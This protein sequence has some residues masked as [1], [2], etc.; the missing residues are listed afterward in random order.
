VNQKALNVK[1]IAF[2]LNKQTGKFASSCFPASV[3][4]LQLH[5]PGFG[6]PFPWLHHAQA[7]IAPK[8]F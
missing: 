7:T 4:K 5:L 1:A 2:E 3:L 8:L 6:E